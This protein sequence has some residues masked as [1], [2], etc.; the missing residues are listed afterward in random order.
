MNNWPAKKY[1]LL[2]MS[3]M[4][5][6]IFFLGSCHTLILDNN[7]DTVELLQ[8]VFN[9]AQ[10]YS[11]DQEV[12]FYRV[13]NQNK[14]ILGYAFYAEGMGQE[15]MTS[16]GGKIPAPIIV[17]VG[18]NKDK[19]TIN[20]I[21]IIEHHESVLFWQLLI[22]EN[23][24]EQFKNLKIVDAYFRQ[25]GGTVDVINGATLSSASILDIVREETIN[26]VPLLH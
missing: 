21:Y 22:T 3:I 14:S 24:F 16:D 25:S 6:T 4:V 9:D 1:L 23:Y 11:Y 17:L 12:A 19:E 26:K 5:S 7:S 20:D 2:S 15:V 10:Y 8:R 13:Y 18:L